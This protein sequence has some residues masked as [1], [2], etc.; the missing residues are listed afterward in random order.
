MQCGIVHGGEA[1]NIVPKQCSLVCEWRFIPADNPDE[2]EKEIRELAKSLE[3]EMHKVNSDTGIDI[4]MDNR[5]PALNTSADS[6][7]VQIAKQLSESNEIGENVS[8]ATEASIFSVVGVP[9]VLI[10]PGSIS[11]AHKPNEFVE[12][13]QLAKCESFM[14]N[15]LSYVSE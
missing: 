6:E 12:I 2:Y 11:Q 1:R 10:G 3:T 13:E 4:L 8:Y 15:L 7:V 5:V 14:K 9:S